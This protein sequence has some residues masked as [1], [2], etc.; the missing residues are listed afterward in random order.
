M[1]CHNFEDRVAVVVTGKYFEQLFDLPVALKGTVEKMAE[2]VIGEEDR[3]VLRDNV[4]CMTFNT[5]ASNTGLILGSCTRIER[6]FGRTLLWL[7]CR[8][9]IL[10]GMFEKCCDIPLSGADIQIF[11][12]IPK[13]IG[14]KSYMTA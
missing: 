14:K 7:A 4:I 8:H 12:K 1:E 9:H 13:S 6:E 2:V 10:K 5:T 11:S 3:F